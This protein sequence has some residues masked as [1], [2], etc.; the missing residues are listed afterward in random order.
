[1]VDSAPAAITRRKREERKNSN[2]DSIIDFCCLAVAGEEVTQNYSSLFLTIMSDDE[3][4]SKLLL[5]PMTDIPDDDD[6]DRGDLNSHNNSG[7]VVVTN[8]EIRGWC[9]YE[10]ASAIVSSLSV[11]LLFP[12]LIESQTMIE[13]AQ[14]GSIRFFGIIVSPVSVCTYLL[15][16]LLSSLRSFHM[17]ATLALQ[18]SFFRLWYSLPLDLLPITEIIENA[19]CSG[20]R[21]LAQSFVS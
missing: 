16:Y 7:S 4:H 17:S 6:G 15:T 19:S 9:F 14:A 11:T 21:S 10:F 3:D 8:E 12:I 18:V 20:A 13:V 1:M 5:Q 2:K